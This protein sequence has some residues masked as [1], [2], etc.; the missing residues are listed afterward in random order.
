M[1]ARSMGSKRWFVLIGKNQ[2]IC[3]L[4]I[5]KEYWINC[6]FFLYKEFFELFADPNVFREGEGKRKKYF[7]C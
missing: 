2:K 6:F 7:N 5:E 4:L 1:R 3:L